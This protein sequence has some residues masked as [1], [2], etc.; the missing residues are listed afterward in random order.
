MPDLNDAI[1]FA[2]DAHTGQ[3]DKA[4]EPYI[5]HPLRV[6]LAMGTNDERITAVLHDVVED[7][8]HVGHGDI[9]ALF[10]EAV[11]AAVFALTRQ[12]GESYPDFIKRCSADP[13]ARAVKLADIADNLSPARSASLPGHLRERYEAARRALTGGSDAG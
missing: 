13:I 9:L 6:M 3:I 7:S 5:L 2:V 4:G 11:H 8:Q 12:D 10:G 1:K